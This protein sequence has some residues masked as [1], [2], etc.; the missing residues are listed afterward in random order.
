MPPRLA[1]VN[2]VLI[3]MICKCT[4]RGNGS[5]LVASHAVAMWR[6]ST[7]QDR[8]RKGA[9]LRVTATGYEPIEGNT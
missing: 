2:D 9:R 7:C 5:V 1:K 6:C 3:T 4:D 8:G